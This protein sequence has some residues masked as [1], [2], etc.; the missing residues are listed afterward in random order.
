MI[1]N[2]YAKTARMQSTVLL[3]SACAKRIHKRR[4]NILMHALVYS[5][6]V[7]F[8]EERNK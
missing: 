1:E 7:S 3:L 8:V 6:A 5:A 2:E 4:R